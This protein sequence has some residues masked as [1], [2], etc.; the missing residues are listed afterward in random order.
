GR[1][2]TS[3]RGF[4]A[5]RTRA[6]RT[7]VP[8]PAAGAERDLAHCAPSAAPAPG[9]TRRTQSPALARG[10]GALARS[11]SSCPR[12]ALFA[13]GLAFVA[14]AASAQEIQLTGPLVGARAL[15]GI[16]PTQVTRVELSG[17]AGP[18]VIAEPRGPASVDGAIEGAVRLLFAETLA[19]SLAAG[20][21]VG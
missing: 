1:G 2:A 12:A 7:L 4:G 3:L 19:P 13:V 9:S 21:A 6:A 15:I 11:R 17:G 16:A 5:V 20:P 18:A 14:R 10:E 8:H